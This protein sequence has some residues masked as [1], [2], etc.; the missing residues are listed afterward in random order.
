MLY[1]PAGTSLAARALSMYYKLIMFL[2]FSFYI[3]FMMFF[4]P[5]PTS[6]SQAFCFYS[7][8]PLPAHIHKWHKDIKKYLLIM[9]KKYFLLFLSPHN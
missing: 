3:L 6:L 7:P 4:Y 9:I 8:F 5:N 2:L 1:F